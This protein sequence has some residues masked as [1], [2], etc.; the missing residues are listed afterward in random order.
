MTG[1]R[2]QLTAEDPYLRNAPD[3]VHAMLD[4]RKLEFSQARERD[5][6]MV[7]ESPEDPQRMI[8]LRYGDWIQES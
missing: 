1:R 7:I 6:P 3:W 5:Y 4:S 2:Y 8:C